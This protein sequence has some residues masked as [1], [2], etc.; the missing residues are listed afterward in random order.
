MDA[1]SALPETVLDWM[2]DHGDVSLVTE[3]DT[4]LGLFETARL[5]HPESKAELFL[6][7][8]SPGTVALF[9]ENKH[10]DS[11]EAYIAAIA[12]VLRQEYELI[13][14]AGVRL[15]VDCRHF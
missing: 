3:L 10:Y 1:E 7:S 8:P 9:M 11:D 4:M 14:N 15:Q 13:T 5:S 2:R 12:E 6:T